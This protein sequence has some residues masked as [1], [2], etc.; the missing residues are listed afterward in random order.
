M[1]NASESPVQTWSQF[2]Y[3]GYHQK[4]PKENIYVCCTTAQK[5]KFSI[6]DFFSKCDQILRK[7][8]KLCKVLLLDESIYPL[9]EKCIL[10]KLCTWNNYTNRPGKSQSDV[11]SNNLITI[12]SRMICLQMMSIRVQWTMMKLIFLITT[13]MKIF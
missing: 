2:H 10:Y 9:E 3:I 7:L 11:H 6:K 8:Q 1:K 13:K 4:G 12:Q 5:I